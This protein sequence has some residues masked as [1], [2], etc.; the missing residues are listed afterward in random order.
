MNSEERLPT[1]QPTDCGGLVN[2]AEGRAV[3]YH[4]ACLFDYYNTNIRLFIHKLNLFAV[5]KFI[6]ININHSQ[7]GLVGRV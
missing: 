7:Q 1:G 6:D 5:A 3:V 4:Y 2:G